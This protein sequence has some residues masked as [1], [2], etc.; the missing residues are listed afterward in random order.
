MSP[1]RVTWSTSGF[2]EYLE[3]LDKA[4]KNVDEVAPQALQAGAEV[5]LAGMAQRVPRDTGNLADHLGIYGPFQDVSD[6]FVYVG[7][8]R[9]KNVSRELAIY[10]TVMEFG[11]VHT[12]ARSY[13]RATLDQDGRK[14]RA[15][16]VAVFKQELGLE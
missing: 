16:M 5:L 8:W 7:L 1:L 9:G 14:A 12:P 6:H 10:A 11:S 15:A 3:Q 2:D 13:I 4:G